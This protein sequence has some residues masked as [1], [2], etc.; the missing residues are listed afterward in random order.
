MHIYKKTH[1]Y[2]RVTLVGLQLQNTIVDA[3]QPIGVWSSLQSMIQLLLDLKTKTYNFKKV[4]TTR[5]GIME[6]KKQCMVEGLI[7]NVISFL[8]PCNLLFEN[9]NSWRT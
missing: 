9:P 3:Y 4:S 1:D 8:I 5:W 2:Q 7:N 6:G